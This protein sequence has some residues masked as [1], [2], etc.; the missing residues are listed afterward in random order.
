M[1][2]SQEVFYFYQVKLVLEAHLSSDVSVDPG[3]VTA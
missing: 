1:Y 2:F 3:E